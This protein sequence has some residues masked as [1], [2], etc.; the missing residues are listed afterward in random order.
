MPTALDRNGQ[1]VAVTNADVVAPVC[2]DCKKP[3]DP[4]T[5]RVQRFVDSIPPAGR[6]YW[7]CASAC[8]PARGG[9]VT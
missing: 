3:G 5:L 8:T 6:A 4:T 7:V 9:R 2:M 1:A